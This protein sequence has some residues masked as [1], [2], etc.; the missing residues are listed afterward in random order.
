MGW[1]DELKTT[2]GFQAALV[3]HGPRLAA[4]LMAALIAI[5]AGFFV[6]SQNRGLSAEPPA[7]GPATGPVGPAG[8][9]D[10][11]LSTLHVSEIT[12][13][14]LFGETHSTVDDANA[15]QTSVQLVLAGV[16]AVPD[17]KRGLAIIGPNAGTAK[18]YTVGSAIPGGVSLYSVYSDRVLLDRS[19]VIE[20]LLLP[21]KAPLAGT[22]PE[23]P[24]SAS[25]G[26]RLAAFAQGN[27]AVLGGLVR[28]QPVFVGTKLT[29]YRIYPGGRTSVGAFT[30]LGLR[31]GDLITGVNG[32]PLDDPARA[33]EILQTLSSLASANLT[34]QRN[35]QSQELTLNLETV[36]SDAE[37][38]AAAELRQDAPSEGPAPPRL[39]GMGGTVAP[40]VVADPDDSEPPPVEDPAEN[41]PE[42][43]SEQ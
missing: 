30:H 22:A 14:H 13:A 3:Q 42:P 39:P 25:G 9:Q 19:G 21:R 27:A 38:V 7:H 11:N 12:S 24:N 41:V 29:G 28:A 31:P 4:G 10:A 2:A 35:G 33:N 36:A 16:L 26:Q 37:N 40:A 1:I 43:P 5:Q 6:T 8:S 20:S 15:P 34:I 32:T 17:P 23:L 18:L